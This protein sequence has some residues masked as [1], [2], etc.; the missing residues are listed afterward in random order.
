L[1]CVAPQVLVYVQQLMALRRNRVTADQI[2]I[3]TPYRK[4]VQKIRTLLAAK[5][6]GGVL[7]SCKTL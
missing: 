7:V 3:I 4:Q 2:A 5:G 6:Y 1:C